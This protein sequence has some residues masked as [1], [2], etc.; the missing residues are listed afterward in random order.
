MQIHRHSFRI[1][2]T[3]ERSRPLSRRRKR[4]ASRYPD[5]SS[6]CFGAFDCRRYY[7]R[8]FLE[9]KEVRQRYKS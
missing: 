8:T 5:M 4:K 6:A 7:Y 2:R 1:Q 3:A 9:V